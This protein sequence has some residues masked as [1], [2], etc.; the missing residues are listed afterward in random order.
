MS[1][2]VEGWDKNG[3]CR[4]P[5]PWRGTKCVGEVRKGLFMMGTPGKTKSI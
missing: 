2:I 5:G 4:D 3:Q 1:E